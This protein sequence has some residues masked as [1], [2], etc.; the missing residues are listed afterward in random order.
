M[1]GK[2]LGIVYGIRFREFLFELSYV[3]VDVFFGCIIS[4]YGGCCLCDGNFMG[5]VEVVY[6]CVRDVEIEIFGDVLSVSDD[7]DVL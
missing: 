1:F 5:V 2:F 7:G 3:K 4:N 6:V